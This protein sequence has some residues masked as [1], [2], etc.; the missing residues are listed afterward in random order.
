MT[1][2]P[3]AKKATPGKKPVAEKATRRKKPVAKGTSF[4][5]T[6]GKRTR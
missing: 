3:V 6:T 4:S 1:E 5:R 2:K